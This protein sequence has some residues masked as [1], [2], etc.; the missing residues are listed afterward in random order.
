LAA[1]ADWTIAMGAK[2][3]TALPANNEYLYLVSSGGGDTS[4]YT[5][6]RFIIELW[7]T[8]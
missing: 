8:R 2:V 1:A 4:E 3:L 6:G 7:G 5:A